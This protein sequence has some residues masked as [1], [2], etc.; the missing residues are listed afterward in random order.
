MPTHA[1]EGHPARRETTAPATTQ[2]ACWLPTGPFPLPPACRLWISSPR[3]PA[4]SATSCDWTRCYARRGLRMVEAYWCLTTPL[5][6]PPHTSLFCCLML[7]PR[8]R[9]RTAP[10]ATILQAHRSAAYPAGCQ[11]LAAA[12]RHLPDTSLAFLT[13][14]HPST[15]A[16]TYLL[17]WQG[18]GT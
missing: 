6:T 8:S 1:G 3:G 4:H 16:F 11:H 14:F 13:F 5:H 12:Y 2:H 10:A 7:P 9:I 17:H 18:D 15:F